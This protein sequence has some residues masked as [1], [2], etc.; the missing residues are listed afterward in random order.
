M[1]RSHEPSAVVVDFCSRSRSADQSDIRIESADLTLDVIVS[2]EPEDLM[3]LYADQ[4]GER[5]ALRMDLFQSE[6]CL[7][8]GRRC[9]GTEIVLVVERAVDARYNLQ[10]E[11]GKLIVF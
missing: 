2:A 9:R 10:R 6:G 8:A 5:A 11:S 3:S 1:Q 7:H 4:I